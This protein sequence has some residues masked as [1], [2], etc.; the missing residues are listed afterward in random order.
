MVRVMSKCKKTAGLLQSYYDGELLFD[1]KLQVEEHLMGCEDCRA[2]LESLRAMGEMVQLSNEALFEEVSFEGFF[3]RIEAEIKRDESLSPQR[4]PGLW[5]Q[6]VK[7]IAGFFTAHKPILATS[8]VT[9][10][11]VAVVF[12]IFG[13]QETTVIE[14]PVVVQQP[15]V[16]VEKVAYD[17]NSTVLISSTPDDDTTVIWL[18]DEYQQLPQTVPEIKERIEKKRRELK[19]NPI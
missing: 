2:R 11:L 10:I 14:K 17:E 18:I 1:E 19:D 5:D 16:V 6:L 9:A 8:L 3:D 12:V 7:P 15:E 4:K 13:Q